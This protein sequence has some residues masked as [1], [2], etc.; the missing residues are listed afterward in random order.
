MNK[1]EGIIMSQ[2]TQMSN[3]ELN[4]LFDSNNKSIISQNSYIHSLLRINTEIKKLA[5][6]RGFKL[7]KIKIK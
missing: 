4:S 2:L 1:Y 5:E 7:A 3:E 6:I